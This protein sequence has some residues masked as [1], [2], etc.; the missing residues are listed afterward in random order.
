[1]RRALAGAVEACRSYLAS[2]GVGLSTSS[3]T[4]SNKNINV[5]RFKRFNS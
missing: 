2:I 1:M 4:K 5:V 3:A